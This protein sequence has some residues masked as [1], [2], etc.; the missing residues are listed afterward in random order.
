MSLQTAFRWTDV[1]TVARYCGM[2]ALIPAGMGLVSAPVAWWSGDHP[3]LAG[4][5][6]MSAISVAAGALLFAC[7]I[8]RVLVNHYQIF[9]IISFSWVVISLL[10]SIPLWLAGHAAPAGSAS[11]VFASW[12]NAL[13]ES[14]SGFT[15]TGLTMA[16]GSEGELTAGLQ[17]WRSFSQWVGGIGIILAVVLFIFSHRQS[18]LL[19]HVELG[20]VILG[21]SVHTTALRVWAIYSLYTLIVIGLLLPTDMSPWEA[22]NY[23]LAAISTGGFGVTGGSLGDFSRFA[24]A[25]VLLGIVL[26]ALSFATHQRAF[27]RQFGKVLESPQMRWFMGTLLVLLVAMF[28]SS[29]A[30]GDHAWPDIVFQAVTSLGTAGF[31]TVDLAAWPAPMLMLMI[32]AMVVGGCEGSTVGG[33]KIS[34]FRR[35][36]LEFGR[37]LRVLR[38]EP[39][40]ITDAEVI[41]ER[42]ETTNRMLQALFLAFLWL[43]TL[44]S[45][46]FAL[47]FLVDA[48]LL[49]I[50]FEATSA[51]G[52]VGLTSG[53]TQPEMDG[54]AKG[55]LML[56]MWLGRLEIIP[57]L[58]I[59]LAPFFVHQVED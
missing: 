10:G 21:K 58:A 27:Q 34:R 33:I 50:I 6:W 57:I 30:L 14:V 13:F 38:E 3:A 43:L 5:L 51:L 56:L 36:V 12:P 15:S 28:A 52:C 53:V 17:W 1:R 45:G 24:Q 46:V 18:R 39:E 26:G 16:A 9:W 2:S 41:E 22:V 19:V 31:S 47:V 23:G 32:M 42:T 44:L 7:G 55:I 4:F 37:T 29:L 49:P 48:P 8:R 25:A 40:A 11:A 54:A 35:L 59:V 20:S